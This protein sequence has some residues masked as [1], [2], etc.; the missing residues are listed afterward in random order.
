M[1][2]GGILDE[3]EGCRGEGVCEEERGEDVE[4]D[5]EDVVVVEENVERGRM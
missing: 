1:R 4:M 5:A 2:G 3:T